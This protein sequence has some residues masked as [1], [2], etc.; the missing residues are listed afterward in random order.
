[1]S[2]ILTFLFPICSYI[3]SR[4]VS[5]ANLCYKKK[6]N[7]SIFFSHSVSTAPCSPN[8]TAQ[9]LHTRSPA[10]FLLGRGSAAT[11]TPIG[12]PLQCRQ[13]KLRT[14]INTFCASPTPHREPR[15]MTQLLV[16]ESQALYVFL[17]HLLPQSF[18]I[19][20][21]CLLSAGPIILNP[22]MDIRGVHEPPIL[23]NYSLY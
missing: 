18:Q 14:Y 19:Y 3:M 9:V 1:M 8:S 20:A 21:Y 6:R 5:L 23:S 15:D 7:Q 2:F 12:P 11:A 17:S 16:V 13:C 4:F 10:D 22:R